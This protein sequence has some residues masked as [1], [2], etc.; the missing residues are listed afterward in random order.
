MTIRG[1]FKPVDVLDHDEE[2]SVVTLERLERR[3]TEE[4]G[5]VRMDVKDLRAEMI[6]RQASMLRWLLGFF[7]AQT[8]ALAALMSAMR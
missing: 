2:I 3:L 4:C 8:A 6:D 5:A 7:V 1:S